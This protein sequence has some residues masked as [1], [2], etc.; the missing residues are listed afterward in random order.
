MDN[1]KILHPLPSDAK[2]PRPY[3]FKIMEIYQEVDSESGEFLRVPNIAKSC[4]PS[5][6]G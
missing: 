5:H 3:A 6:A 2:E 1:T 4:T